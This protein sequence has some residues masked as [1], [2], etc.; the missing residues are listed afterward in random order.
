MA[1]FDFIIAGA[2]LA[3]ACA[4]LALSRKGSVLVVEPH[5]PA[6]GGSGAAA[7]MVNPILGMRARPVWRIREAVEAL[8]HLVADAGADELYRR[9]PT[10][11]PAYGDDQVAWFKESAVDYPAHARWLS[12][13]ECIDR[14]PVVRAPEGALLITTGGAV[15]LPRFVGCILDAARQRGAEVRLGRSVTGW[16][17]YDG[18]PKDGARIGGGSGALEDGIR[19]RGGDGTLEHGE[20]NL[21]GAGTLEGGERIR[22]SSGKLKDGG[23]LDGGDA[24][25]RGERL[26]GG[27][28]TLDD[29]ER[30]RGGRIILALGRGYARFPEL[31]CLRLHQ[32]KGQTIRLSKPPDLP[33]DLPHLAGRGYVAHD[34][35][36]LVA[37]STY[38]H[39]FDHLE[40]TERQTRAILAKT[41]RMLPALIESDVLEARA[42]VRVTVPGIRLPMVG[43]LPGR[44]NIWIFTGFGAKGLLTAPL[45]ARELP[46]YFADPERI[47][48]E[49]RV[50]LTK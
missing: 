6:A 29:G 24:L 26:R 41:S 19:I 13:R 23:R 39:E 1:D 40:P 4:A 11:R 25:N 46:A 18:S 28:V 16:D 49:T 12:P 44:R 30:I 9:R 27:L 15:D 37:G 33:P 10:L 2:G 8:D 14:Y 48:P 35:G 20:R 7:G 50:R 36:E 42:G 5:A 34:G 43:P 45:A 3:G 38:E 47:P 32:I 31:E 22:E 21:G 17:E